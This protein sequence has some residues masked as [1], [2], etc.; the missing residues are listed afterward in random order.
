MRITSIELKNFRQLKEAKFEFSTDINKN[1]TIIMG[2]NGTGKTTLAQA[3]SWCLYGETSFKIESVLNKEVENNLES[4]YGTLVEVKIGLEHGD[5]KYDILREQKYQKK[6]S[7]IIQ[8][9]T[10]VRMTMKKKDGTISKI[11][12]WDREVRK[13]LPSELS[14]YFFF[15]GERIE[16]MSKEIQ[17]GK[18]SNEFAG[19]VRGLLGLNP[20]ISALEHLK[21]RSKYSV[22][23]RYEESYNQNSNS[24]VKDYTHKLNVLRER[25][26]KNNKR[27][28]EIK[29]QKA[30]AKE[31]IANCKEKLKAI[32]ESKK[33]QET[34]DKKEIE[35][36]SY[37]NQKIEKTQSLLKD[38]NSGA[39]SFFSRY[40]II[41]TINELKN[42]KYE[43]KT[44][45]ELSSKAIKYLLEHHK[46]ICGRDIVEG[47]EEYKNLE[48][49]L[50]YLPPK[51]LGTLIG[52]FTRESD[53]KISQKDDIYRHIGE[54]CEDID[55]IDGKIS[56]IRDELIA[57]DEKLLGKDVTKTV[58]DLTRYRKN[59]EVDLDKLKEE[60]EKIQKD[61][62]EN[63]LFITQL[64]RKITELNLANKENRKLEIYKAYALG[65]HEYL[66]NI[67]NEK[68][69]ELRR[70]LQE[71]INFIFKNI[72]EGGLSLDIDK[73]YGIK[74]QA[75]NYETET[76][77]AQSISVIFAF[78]SGI[79]KLAREYQNNENKE[80]ASEP[81]PLVMDAPLS[82]FDK[83]RIRKVCEVLP[84][85]AE[86]VIIFIKDTDGDLA[87]ENL[88]NKV[89]R[90]YNLEKIN[91][92]NT[93]IR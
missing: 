25:V 16:K 22:V 90:M 32:E 6:G 69:T 46:C 74:V 42:L 86:Q 43:E 27:L 92:F 35:K 39:L 2:N 62:I 19:A 82:A 65:V 1:V 76:S 72:Y 79:I 84:E 68:E 20:I 64:E 3:F 80:L 81:Y 5:V 60:E 53:L 30:S 45:P 71:E 56:E 93:V 23:G 38:F 14:K 29:E 28:V 11:K 78:I 87:K 37:E 67:L 75:D 48:K 66:N 85:I 54:K 15:D 50:E 83:H 34:R 8:E 41:D 21:P 91:E 77:T 70:I 89:G 24:K 7:K 12:E 36:K 10:E 63:E 44:I 33:L 52:I 47:T 40:M 57:L 51:S 58:N 88:K 49:L 17:G 31:V 26:E 9:P 18:R 55:K 59:A 13:I 4:G 61:K 73:N